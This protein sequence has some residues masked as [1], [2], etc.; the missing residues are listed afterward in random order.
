MLLIDDY[1]RL[2][3]VAFLKEKF[4]GFE[5]FKMFK[6]MVDTEIGLKINA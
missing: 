6:A 3:W 1:S 4:E 5:K 2:M